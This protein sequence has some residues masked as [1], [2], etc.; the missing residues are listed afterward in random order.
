MKR[1]LSFFLLAFCQLIQAQTYV[2]FPNSAC[3]KYEVS[4]FES[5]AQLDVTMSGDTIIEGN[6]YKQLSAIEYES[7]GSVLPC[8]GYYVNSYPYI[9]ALRQDSLKNI[10][11]RSC[12]PNNPMFYDVIYCGANQSTISANQD[13]LIYK[14]GA[15]IGDTLPIYN[16]N[17]NQP[18]IVT[19]IDS[20]NSFH[21]Y[22]EAID[23]G[24]Y[25]K[26]Y[27]V[28]GLNYLLYNNDLSQIED[29]SYWIEGVG[30][31]ENLLVVLLPL[32][33]T[34][35]YFGFNRWRLRAFV[36]NPSGSC[37]LG[38]DEELKNTRISSSPNPTTKQLQ[39]Q[40]QGEYT[41]NLSVAIYN[42]QGT[43]INLQHAKNTNAFNCTF[44]LSNQ[45]PGIYVVQT[46]T[47]K[48]SSVQKIIKQ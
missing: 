32:T 48:G 41:P 24:S 36:D 6:T 40:Y 35:P 30:S 11:F 28:S 1:T 46:V 3:W 9:G 14:F 43:L 23:L 4:C 42:L 33:T 44:D 38:I 37:F 18:L 19:A 5:Y 21:V 34:Q 15:A 29:K 20:V 45:P 27:T 39:Y 10:W 22:N 31:L 8:C 13:I 2:P 17:T 12:C 25:R 26:R 16:S 7:D 47:N